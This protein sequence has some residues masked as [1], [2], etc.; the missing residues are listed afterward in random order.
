MTKSEEFN[1]EVGT[2]VSLANRELEN[3][4]PAKQRIKLGLPFN[5]ASFRREKNTRVFYGIDYTKVGL[6]LKSVDADTGQVVN[7]RVGVENE[8]PVIERYVEKQGV[9]Q[10]FLEDEPP[11]TRA[12]VEALILI[13]KEF[14]LANREILGHFGSENPNDYEELEMM[15]RIMSEMEDEIRE[16]G[17]RYEQERMTELCR[18]GGIEYIK[19][20]RS[21]EGEA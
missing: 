3:Y 5:I 7:W 19:R 2:F 11:A 8:N 4:L 15:L 18:E 17:L 16:G 9:C 12:R 10:G 13:G 21:K 1:Q 14:A 6:I 20:A